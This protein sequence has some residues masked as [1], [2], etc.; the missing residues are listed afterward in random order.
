[1]HRLQRGRILLVIV[2][3]LAVLVL[4]RGEGGRREEV[5]DDSEEKGQEVDEA[6]CPKLP[7]ITFSKVD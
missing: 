2:T 6:G 3:G 5:E 4:L 7:V 1:M